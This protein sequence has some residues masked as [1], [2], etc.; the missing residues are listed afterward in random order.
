M[1]K[2][3]KTATKARALFAPAGLS[4]R[5]KCTGI[6]VVCG[7]SSAGKSEYMRH[8]I[9]NPGHF[10][11]MTPV[12]EAMFRTKERKALQTRDLFHL[13]IA[14]DTQAADPNY[15][16]NVNHHPLVAKG[17]FATKITSVD[18]LVL[19]SD[20][21]RER[22]STRVSASDDLG[23]KGPRKGY[24]TVNKLQIFDACPIADRYAVWCDYFE[25][26]QA[27]IRYIHSGNRKY[28]NVADRQT[29]I[30]IL[31][32]HTSQ[33]VSYVHQDRQ[34]TPGLVAA[35]IV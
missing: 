22:I 30:D 8:L 7:F 26:M 4:N 33:F 6:H 28:E 24:D 21:L 14:N 5:H 17:L 3:I 20:T 13:D 23:R 25:A 27:E 34:V 11:G 35:P 18:I 2:L 19:T 12:Y 10:Y 9:T 1:I 16:P 31:N 29:A 15:A 32:S